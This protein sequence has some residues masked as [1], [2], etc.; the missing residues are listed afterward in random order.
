M[1]KVIDSHIHCGIQNVSQPFEDIEP[2]LNLA[3]IDGACLYAPVEDIYY[4][5]TSHFDDNETWIKCRCDAHDYLLKVGQNKNQV[6]PYYFVWNDFTVEDLEKD[7]FGIKWHHHEGEP[8]Y[9][10]ADLKCTEMIDAICS[11]NLPIVLE[12]TFRQTLR[13]IEQVAGRTP[14]IIPH[15][16]LLNGGFDRLL[17]AGIWND[18][19]IYADTALAGRFEISSFLDTF[20]SDRLIFGSD[21]PFG[22]PGSQL[23]QIKKMGIH[24]KDLEKICGENILKLL[25][26]FH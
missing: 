26:V 16:G 2:L 21:Y 13:F 8:V 9:H 4:R 1:L 14:V 24:K 6:Y 22:M 7:F 3:G 23:D 17:N 25:R 18:D 12:E 10:Y 11:K 5:Y 15:L 20:G 19:N